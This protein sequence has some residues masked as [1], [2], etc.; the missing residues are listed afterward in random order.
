MAQHTQLVLTL[1]HS[2]CSCSHLRCDLACKL[3]Q[4]IFSEPSIRPEQVG[5]N[6]G[7]SGWA[8]LL[9]SPRPVPPAGSR[10][11]AHITH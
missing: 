1:L 8:Q 5:A 4:L 3:L 9:H 7:L 2:L 11:G 6:Q 10:R